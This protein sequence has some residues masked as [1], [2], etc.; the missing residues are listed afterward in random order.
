M[1]K[2][3][4]MVKTPLWGNPECDPIEGDQRHRGIGQCDDSEYQCKS[5]WVSKSGKIP[6]ANSLPQWRIV[7]ITSG[8]L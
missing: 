7:L 5:L 8:N 2:V 6:D 4:R 3:E 1:I